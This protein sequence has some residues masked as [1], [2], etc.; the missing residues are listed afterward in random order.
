MMEPMAA[1]V[2]VEEPETAPKKK[3]AR[4]VTRPRLPVTRPTRLFA[5]ATRRLERPPASITEPATIKNG[6]A[7]MVK[8]A[9]CVYN[10]ETM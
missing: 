7:I 6:M 8:F 5:T 1:T 3:H 9:V 4:I 2:A 10:E